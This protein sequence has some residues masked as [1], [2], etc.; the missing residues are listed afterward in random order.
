MLR[1]NIKTKIFLALSFL[2]LFLL[3]FVT[4]A[5][6]NYNNPLTISLADRLYCRINGCSISGNLTVD[7]D[8]IISGNL[9]TVG[10]LNVTGNI[11]AADGY[12]F[13]GDG[14]LLTG[15]SSGG[16]CSDAGEC[17]NIAYLNY[18]NNGNLTTTGSLIIQL[19]NDGLANIGYAN[20]IIGGGGKVPIALG[21]RLNS[22]G[23]HTTAIGFGST[24]S[25]VYTTAIGHNNYAGGYF[26]T[27][28]GSDTTADGYYTTAIGY[29]TTSKGYASTAMGRNTSAIGTYSTAMGSN[30]NVTGWNSLGINLNNSVFQTLSKSN[31]M[32]IMGGKVGIG[33]VSPSYT[34]DIAGNLRLSGNIISTSPVKIIDEIM[35]NNSGRLSYFSPN[36]LNVSRINV[37]EDVCILGGNCLSTAGGGS[38]N[39][40]HVSLEFLNVTTD[41]NAYDDITISDD[42]FVHSYAYF[43]NSEAQHSLC[44]YEDGNTCGEEFYWSDSSDEFRVSDSFEAAGNIEATGLISSSDIYTTGSG[45]ELWLGTSTQESANFRADEDGHVDID[46]DNQALYFGESQDGEIYWDSN[47]LIIYSNIGNVVIMNDTTGSK[48]YG[49]IVYDRAIEMTTLYDKNKG[50]A[51]EQIKDVSEYLKDGKPD[52]Q[53]HYAYARV[54]VTDYDNCHEELD[55][56]DDDGIENYNL[57]CDTKTVEG[58]NTNQRVAT[59]EQA[60]YELKQEIDELK[61]ELQA[62]KSGQRTVSIQPVN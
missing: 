14:S 59:C 56:I 28:I 4:V 16:N 1:K 43:G 13:I 27:A 25:G 34:L 47:D 15:I 52:K 19:T 38:V 5:Q 30:I 54:D 40:T 22:I 26:S 57:V 24:A 6:R 62:L 23:D 60:I 46:A 44:F 9:T 33:T 37:S 48:T 8:L 32:A 41:I 42:L 49:N 53:S 36:S 12:Y 39:D 29:E 21:N 20:T 51:L 17:P 45:D 7:G 58:L 10:A 55:F 50:S 61:A 11:T 18:E 31:T 35:I 2:F 3:S